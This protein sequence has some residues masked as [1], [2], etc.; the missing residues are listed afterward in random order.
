MTT[1]YKAPAFWLQVREN[2][3]IDNF[4]AMVDYL[5]GFRYSPDE[6]LPDELISTLDCLDSLLSRISEKIAALSFY[7]P[8]AFDFFPDRT[9]DL[10]RLS[11]L[12]E[13]GI[14]S[15]HKFGR[16]PRRLVLGFI[17]LI[18]RSGKAFRNE[19]VKKLWDIAVAA[20][21]GCEFTNI[22]L[23]W[24]DL[25]SRSAGN[26]YIMIE[27]CAA[28]V[29]FKTPPADVSQKYYENG[30]LICFS[31]ETVLSDMNLDTYLRGETA[32]LVDLVGLLK[33]RVKK[34]DRLRHNRFEDL[35][36]TSKA[37]FN[38]LRNFRPSPER[39]V[40]EYAD[41]DEIFVKVTSVEGWRITAVTLDPAYE[42]VTSQVFTGYKM[43]RVPDVK[44]LMNI[45]RAG[46]ILKVKYHPHVIMKFNLG[47]VTSSYYCSE[48]LELAARRV[49]GIYIDDYPA[50]TLWR[51]NGGFTLSIDNEYL[52]KSSDAVKDAVDL[53]IT[54]DKPLMLSV[55]YK[56]NNPTAIYANVDPVATEIK[57]FTEVDAC[58]N[59]YDDFLYWCD[60]ECPG[61]S[62][63][64]R[65][66]EL[67]ESGLLLA[68]LANALCYIIGNTRMSAGEKYEYA[69]AGGMLSAMCGLELNVEYMRLCREYQSR[70]LD[71]SCNRD[72]RPLPLPEALA[73]NEEAR[74]WSEIVGRLAQY[75]V[76][77]IEV[78]SESR[79]PL[80]E[81]VAKLVEA[82][83]N[84][85]GTI[86][87]AE[88]NNI[89]LVIAQT[90]RVEDEFVPL[91]TEAENFGVE[92]Q[93]L[94]FKQSIVYPPKNH[95]Q[96]AGSEADPEIQKW[97][98][99]KAVCGFMNSKF[100]GELL[101]GVNDKGFATGVDSDFDEL[102]NRG[103]IKAPN[104]DNYSRYVTDEIKKA[105]CE[106]DTERAASDIHFKNV[107]YSQEQTSGGKYIIRIT[108]RP[109]PRKPVRFKEE[110]RPE[111]VEESYVRLNCETIVLTPEKKEIVAAEKLRH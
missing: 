98:I 38:G 84:L 48:A 18:F 29:S 10:A 91:D 109:N 12:Y 35:V 65:D 105:F 51:T 97:A 22:G 5:Y 21:R 87:L 9:L 103:L 61:Y 107:S 71:F 43:D 66:Y 96:F 62:V 78:E 88:Q 2:Y 99:L 24:T 101:L 110:K 7:E 75:K 28:H 83:N 90:L 47:E 100:G 52:Q 30:G 67:I 58:E 56:V 6:P 49:P 59:F 4:D 14:L 111:G 44:H 55:Y 74:S 76:N 94:E 72:V 95:R 41:G 108:V 20:L 80:G 15:F 92:S 3:I 77:E 27:K 60:R 70:L 53:A 11:A 73:D 64:L 63:D 8:L 42:R 17:N 82:A 19:V 16:S 25:K 31:G 23:S 81:K 102:Y 1:S 89:K 39:K 79:L 26:F 54:E 106:Y 86:S 46:D 37:L 104:L 13:A 50:G 68:P 34:E 32:D 85:T 57:P 93:V 40:K 69:L 33:V 45:L 36:K